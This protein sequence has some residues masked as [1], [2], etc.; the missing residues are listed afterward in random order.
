MAADQKGAGN[1]CL[2]R[3]EEG[4][5]GRTV[6]LDRVTVGR[7]VF[8][9]EVL[10]AA[11]LRS[12]EDLVARLAAQAAPDLVLDVEVR[13]IAADNL[14]IHPEEVEGRLG[15]SFLHLRV[16]DRSV[17]DV[18]AGPELPADTVAGRFI[19]D[20]EA[21]IRDAEAAG[22]LAAAEQARQVLRLGRRLLLDDP[23]RVSLA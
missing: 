18:A 11:G 16:R 21:R 8:R 10:D 4:P 1:V 9:S 13:G 23:S 12:Q 5:S 15:G 3:L 6:R 22:D 2:V 19:A 20:L 17:T 14:E 7:T